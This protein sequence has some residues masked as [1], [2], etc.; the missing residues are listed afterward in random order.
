MDQTDYLVAAKLIKRE[1]EDPNNSAQPMI[2]VFI[3]FFQSYDPI[4]NIDHFLVD[5]GLTTLESVTI[6]N[7]AMETDNG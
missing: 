5:C 2:N 6:L 4:F 7:R 3:E 1:L